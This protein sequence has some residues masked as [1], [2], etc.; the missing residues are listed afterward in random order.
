M[1]RGN[2]GFKFNDTLQKKTT[3]HKSKSTDELAERL[4]EIQGELCA[5][6]NVL[7]HRGWSYAASMTQ[8]A[9]VSVSDA[10]ETITGEVQ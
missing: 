8:S 5:I 10:V 4:S 9:K 2:L 3:E 7:A 1:F 6:G